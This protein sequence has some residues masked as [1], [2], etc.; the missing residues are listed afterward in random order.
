MGIQFESLVVGRQYTRPALATMWD[1]RD[2]HAIG[3]GIIAP[4]GSNV[5]VAFITK[6]KQAANTQYDD[7]FDGK[8]LRIE[9]ETNHQH[10]A[11]IIDSHD[12]G[13]EIHLFYRERHHSP[14]IY[15]GTAY[16]VNF[17]R[18]SD[19]PSRFVLETTQT[20]QL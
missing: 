3:R 11:R 15:C 14:F 13:D 5:I 12:N 16:L 6:E 1:Y 2:W 8:V 10:D 19:V 4:R 7:D 20:V 9:G 18:L 17:T